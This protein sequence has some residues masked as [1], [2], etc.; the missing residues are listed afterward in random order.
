MYSE[1]NLTEGISL[2][3]EV[4]FVN[5]K[6]VLIYFFVENCPISKYLD[7]PLRCKNPELEK[8]KKFSFL[9]VL[10]SLYEVTFK[11]KYIIKKTLSCMIVFLDK[12]KTRILQ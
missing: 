3:S 12:L 9:L 6:S 1:E 5:L 7:Y 11:P 4:G 10:D 8:G 2:D